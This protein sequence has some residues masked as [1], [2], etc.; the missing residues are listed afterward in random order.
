MVNTAPL[1]TP[2]FVPPVAYASEY[3]GRKLPSDTCTT[4][5]VIPTEIVLGELSGQYENCCFGDVSPINDAKTR[6]KIVE[7]TPKQEIF[8][9]TPVLHLIVPIVYYRNGVLR[10][11]YCSFL[12]QL[13]HES[14]RRN[15]FCS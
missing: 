10:N 13:P 4:Y 15:Y 9:A 14:T 7:I 2:P 1:A 5:A 6:R 11:I 8:I 12:L 3:S